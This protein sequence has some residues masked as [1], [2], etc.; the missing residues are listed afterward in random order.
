MS[1]SLAKSP[2]SKGLCVSVFAEVKLLVTL[3][4]ST[5]LSN[6]TPC[7]TDAVIDLTMISTAEATNVHNFTI[8]CINGERSPAQVELDIKR[9]NKILMFPKK[10][11][12]NVHKPR[13]KEVAAR[14]FRDLEHIGIFYCESKQEVP[15]LEKVTTINNF[16]RCGFRPHATFMRSFHL[17]P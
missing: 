7:P 6:T 16:G 17:L 11:N 4:T 5:T 2:R 15:P 10:P 9:D 3:I 12:F 8:Y 13:I 1:P 14:D